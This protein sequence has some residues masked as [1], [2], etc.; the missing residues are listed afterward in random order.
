LQYEY[1]DDKQFAYDICRKYSPA[2]K[3][4]HA[5]YS[6][7]IFYTAKKW[8]NKPKED[9]KAEWYF[10]PKKEF[11]RKLEE[12]RYI[13]TS[14]KSHVIYSDT[15]GD[16]Y[17]F[18]AKLIISRS[19]R[20]SK[21]NPKSSP[22]Q[23]MKLAKFS[24]YIYSILN[25]HHTF[26][27]WMKDKYGSSEYV[28][29]CILKMPKEYWELFRMLRRKKAIE[30]IQSKIDKE[31]TEIESMKNEIIS[32]L[33]KKDQSYMLNS[34]IIL[35]FYSDSNDDAEEINPED[36]N[37][38]PEEKSAGDFSEGMIIK[39]VIEKSI[40]HLEVWDR[41][42]LKMYWGNGTSASSIVKFIKTDGKKMN[43]EKLN[44]KKDTD[45]VSN[46]ARIIKELNKNLKH[47]HKDFYTKYNPDERVLR[48]VVK[49]FLENFE[50]N[51]IS[52]PLISGEEQWYCE[53]CDT[54]FSNIDGQFDYDEDDIVRMGMYVCPE[55]WKYI[56]EMTDEEVEN[57]RISAL[58]KREHDL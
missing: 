3:A 39:E 32:A 15:I 7:K 5:E 12:K 16:L 35:D 49:T 13:K 47:I 21:I 50:K 25:H 52:L 51:D 1:T 6:K 38:S 27:E 40:S 9:E 43:L 14:D 54:F 44:I 48:H 55:C 2:L 28:P 36:S 24:T 53:K 30:Y 57:L 41:R 22:Q 11:A 20:Y 29:T 37:L 45:I 58:E 31:A 19:C 4:M 26:Q 18:L 10:N 56:S 8:D 42:L 17:A 34:K 23:R 46:I 33:N